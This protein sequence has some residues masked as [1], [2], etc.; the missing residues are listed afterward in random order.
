MVRFKERMGGKVIM[1][2][3]L[4]CSIT[5][6][7]DKRSIN[8]IS[9]TK[10][11]ITS[12]TPV[13]ALREYNYTTFFLNSILSIFSQIFYS[14]VCGSVSWYN[15]TKSDFI[16]YNRVIQVFGISILNQQ[17]TGRNGL[18]YSNYTFLILLTRM[19]NYKDIT[20][21]SMLIEGGTK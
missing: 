9:Y 3:K 6:S 11:G 19:L 17:L 8:R 13:N 4:G 20:P 10:T 5:H 12:I 7:T 15:Y 2:M 18:Y 14:S 21:F 16:S 1:I